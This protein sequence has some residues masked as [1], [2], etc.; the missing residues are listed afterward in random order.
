MASGWPGPSSWLLIVRRTSTS[1]AT[2]APAG[3]GAMEAAE[4]LAVAEAG[5]A[6]EA[7]AGGSVDALTNA[8]ARTGCT[9]P[10]SLISKSS[11]DRPGTGWPSLS[12]TVT[13]TVTS[14]TPERKVVC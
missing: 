11:G 10:L 13:S 4:G 6:C 7:E 5:A 9:L 1:L 3:F 12:I 14:D 8:I 2:I